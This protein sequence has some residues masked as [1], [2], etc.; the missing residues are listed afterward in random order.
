[1]SIRQIARE[2]YKS[3]Q[4]VEGFE[5]ELAEAPPSEQDEIKERLRIARAELQQLENIMAGAKSP[6]PSG[7]TSSTFKAGK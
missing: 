6:P 5:K 4:Q 1:M 2:L 3:K 7:V